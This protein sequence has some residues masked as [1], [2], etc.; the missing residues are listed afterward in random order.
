MKME[1][2]ITWIN[3]FYFSIQNK[4]FYDKSW[5]LIKQSQIPNNKLFAEKLLTVSDYYW[6]KT[7]VYNHKKIGFSKLYNI[8]IIFLL[9]YFQAFP[10]KM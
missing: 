7:E 4:K 8:Y 10:N 1:S 9:F 5:T 2:R 6:S 3:W